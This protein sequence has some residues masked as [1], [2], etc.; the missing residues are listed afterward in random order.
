MR[1]IRVIESFVSWQGECNDT[2][3]RMIILRFK[4]CN[5]NNCG[6]G[7]EGCDTQVKMRINMEYELSLSKIQ[8]IVDAEKCNIL[9]TGGEPTFNLNLQSTIDTINN[10]K[11][12]LFNV[13][14]NGC[15]LLGL[16]EKVNKNKKV[17]YLLS[18][19]LFNDSDINFYMDLVNKV[20]DNESVHIKLVYEE[21]DYVIEFLNYLQKIEF[22]ND[23]IW[24]M[25]EGTTREKLLEHAPAVFNAAEKYK[26]NF[27]SREHIIYGFV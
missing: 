13:E 9:I 21:R 20:K 26:V 8:E 22:D 16:I 11:C 7:S 6:F 1:N 14:T 23:R 3:K 27:S 18:P 24:L 10:I 15:D 2:G 5:R 17:K 4:R 12:K 25:P 19:K